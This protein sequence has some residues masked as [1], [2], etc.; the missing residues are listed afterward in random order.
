MLCRGCC[1]R[2]CSASIYQQLKSIFT[3]SVV[4]EVDNAKNL[5]LESANLLNYQQSA[6][7]IGFTEPASF[8]YHC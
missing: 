1:N 4:S 2:D 5:G 7:F 3:D 6:I 8:N